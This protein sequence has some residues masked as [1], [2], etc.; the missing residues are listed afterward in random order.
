[1]T[2]ITV[3]QALDNIYTSLHNGNDNIDTHIQQLKEA[4]TAAG[5]KSVEVDTSRLAQNNREGRKMMQAYFRKRGVAVTFSE[6]K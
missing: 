1:M 2:T 6:K 3:T 5:Q 4:L